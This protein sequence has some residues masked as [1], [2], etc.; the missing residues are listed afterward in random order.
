M[1]SRC[2]QDLTRVRVLQ[3]FNSLI[4]EKTSYSGSTSTSTKY[5][6]SV[7]YQ[8]NISPYLQQKLENLKNKTPKHIEIDKPKF[9]SQIFNIIWIIDKITRSRKNFA[10]KLVGKTEKPGI[11]FTQCPKCDY[12]GLSLLTTSNKD[13][14]SPTFSSKLKKILPPSQSQKKIN[15]NYL[16][17]TPKP[18]SHLK[19]KVPKLNFAEMNKLKFRRHV[20]EGL[21][22]LKQVFQNPKKQ[23]LQNLI[24]FN[25]S[26]IEHSSQD[27][28]SLSQN[29][30]FISILHLN[31]PSP[32]PSPSPSLLP[33]SSKS[34]SRS[35]S[36]TVRAQLSVFK[37]LFARL[38]KLIFKQKLKIFITLSNDS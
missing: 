26:V 27:S 17:L 13:Q 25:S 5:L 33:P 34:I 38:K 11:A 22:I 36:P 37:I 16:N 3:N 35:P 1:N 10:F 21:N 19:V 7:D 23:A 18:D 30:P 32:F 9:S 12:I 2:K 31:S 28:P 4:S 29:Y 14:F 15:E 24:Q 8:E 6:N 20:T